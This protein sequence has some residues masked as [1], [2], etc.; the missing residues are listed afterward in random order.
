MILS[1]AVKYIGGDPGRSV[2]NLFLVLNMK[3]QRKITPSEVNSVRAIGLMEGAMSQGVVA[4]Q[5][6]V[7]RKP[8]NRCKKRHLNGESLKDKERSGR[9]PVA[10]IA[11]IASSKAKG[12]ADRVCIAETKRKMPSLAVYVF[13]TCRLNCTPVF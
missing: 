12:S 2:S 10:A 7:S 13:L 11:K 3:V 5:C 4:R 8:V 6:N 9:P 1:F